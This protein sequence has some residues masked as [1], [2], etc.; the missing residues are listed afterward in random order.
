[1]K[2]MSLTSLNIKTHQDNTVPS[3]NHWSQILIPPSRWTSVLIWLSLWILGVAALHSIKVHPKLHLDEIPPSGKQQTAAAPPAI[4]IYINCTHL[5]L[6]SSDA[7]CKEEYLI[8]FTLSFAFKLEGTA[9]VMKLREFE[10]KWLNFL[11]ILSILF[12]KFG[13]C[14]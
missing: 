6:L 11:S 9:F 13:R 4:S 1:M 8:C 5:E 7:P 12:N 14:Q 2:L 3:K 10:T